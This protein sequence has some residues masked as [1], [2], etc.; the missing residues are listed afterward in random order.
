MKY[1]VIKIFYTDHVC[2]KAGCNQDSNLF[3]LKHAFQSM[4]FR[5]HGHVLVGREVQAVNWMRRML[6]TE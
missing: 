1:S 5:Q 4:F 2:D 6:E 3:F